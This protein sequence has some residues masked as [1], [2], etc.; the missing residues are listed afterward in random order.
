MDRGARRRPVL[1]MTE[2]GRDASPRSMRATSLTL[3]GLTM[4]QVYICNRCSEKIDGENQDWVIISMDTSGV[5]GLET[6]AH[7]ECEVKRLKDSRVT[8]VQA[9]RAGLRAVGAGQ[10][11][12]AGRPRSE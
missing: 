12:P 3:R 9:S 1:E 7:A 2:R 10:E 4:P 8:S 11:P 5:S 6:R